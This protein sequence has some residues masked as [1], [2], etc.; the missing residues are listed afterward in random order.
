MKN[1]IL[2]GLLSL[3][4]SVGLWM[5]V[6]TYVTT[7]YDETFYNVPV[8]LQGEA[9]L[10]ERGL[11][12]TSEKKP[13]V[14]L[15]L[16]G[17]RSDMLNLNSSNITLTADVSKIYEPGVHALTYV[18][19]YPG[20]VPNNAI[21][22]QNRNPE[23]VLVTVEE[24]GSKAVE[25]A[26]EYTGTLPE[27]L[28]YDKENA[29]LD[30]PAINITGPKAVVERITQAKIQVDLT[31]RSETIVEQYAYTL[32]DKDG[33]PVD[34]ALITTD[35]ETVHLTLRIQRVKEVALKLNVIAGGGATEKNS[36]IKIDPA[37]IRV[38]GSETLLEGF[39]TWEIGTVKLADLAADA[40]LTF[41]LNLPEGITNETGLTE[42]QVEIK[43]PE[44]QTKTLLNITNIKP[45]NVPAGLEAD[46]ITQSLEK[47]TVRGPGEQIA[48][49]TE[50]DITAVV[51]FTGAQPGT[52]TMNVQITVDARFPGVGAVGTY[53]VSATLA[54]PVGGT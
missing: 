24:R 1:K 18:P 48:Q 30:Y 23:R 39:D 49:I 50:G 41:P 10:E 26:V 32:C 31:N 33:T 7:D 27:G 35:V 25:V 51:D 45:V 6:V 21:S 34:A 16:A 22:V 53:S 19:S 38:S 20:N 2:A 44:L 52:A 36:Q 8:V 11:M 28:I 47:V 5:Y 46:L 29:A 54:A 9:A 43:F 14:S 37:A 3:A 15:K 42:V 4:I 12:I 13:T 40:V 17:N